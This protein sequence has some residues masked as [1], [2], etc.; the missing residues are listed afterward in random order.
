MQKDTLAIIVTATI[1]LPILY[2]LEEL[3]S[4]LFDY[5]PFLSIIT[6]AIGFWFVVVGMPWLW[7]HLRKD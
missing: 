6:I 2:G 3:N 5:S 4:I 1:G 7:N